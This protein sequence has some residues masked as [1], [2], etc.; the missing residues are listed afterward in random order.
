MELA[1][2][3]RTATKLAWSFESDSGVKKSGSFDVPGNTL[4]NAPA[5]GI[6][7]D[8][9]PEQG[10]NAGSYRIRVTSADGKT[11]FLD[12]AATRQFGDLSTLALEPPDSNDRIS[13]NLALNPVD[14]YVRVVGDF[15]DYDNRGQ[16]DQGAEVQ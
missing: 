1:A 2:F 13:I 8:R 16:I 11:T 6:N 9:L 15:I 5:T 10:Q 3:S 7:F 12:W 4:V 14:D